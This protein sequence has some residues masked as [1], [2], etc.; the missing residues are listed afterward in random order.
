[1]I[2]VLAGR[3]GEMLFKNMGVRKSLKT[4]SRYILKVALTN[5]IKINFLKGALSLF[6]FCEGNFEDI[7]RRHL[8][9]PICTLYTTALYSTARYSY[10]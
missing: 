2:Q 4:K 7:A 8:D 6:F 1:M 9:I 5:K 10:S 3:D